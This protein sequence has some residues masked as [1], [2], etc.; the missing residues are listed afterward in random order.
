[1][2]EKGPGLEVHSV[3]FEILSPSRLAV[4]LCHAVSM[5]NKN[6]RE[7]EKHWATE[8]AKKRKAATKRSTTH[9]EDVNQAAARMVREAT[10]T[11]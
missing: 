6:K 1:L 8:A 7:L 5:K 3:Q 9:P 2:A 11:K 10:H 4:R